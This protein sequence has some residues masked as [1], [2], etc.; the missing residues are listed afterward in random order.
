LFKEGRKIYAAFR[1]STRRQFFISQQ[2][3]VEKKKQSERLNLK[4]RNS[5][6]TVTRQRYFLRFSFY[7]FHPFSLFLS[8]S[9]S[10]C[11]MSF[12]VLKDDDAAN[13]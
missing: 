2:E 8:I 5:R 4:E 11:T 3:K 12:F 7:L 13:E 10:V 9:L 1:L 6:D